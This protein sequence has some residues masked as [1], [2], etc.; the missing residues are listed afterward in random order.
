MA[1]AISIGLA[2]LLIVMGFYLVRY[3]TL[4]GLVQRRIRTTKYSREKVTG[5]DA[6][7]WGIFYIFFGM[8]LMVAAAHLLL[9]SFAESGAVAS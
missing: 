7:G 5:R 3:G 1:R 4:A 9:W 2:A 6:V 8:A